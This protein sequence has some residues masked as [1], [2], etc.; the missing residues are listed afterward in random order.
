MVRN[1]PPPSSPTPTAENPQCNLLDVLLKRSSDQFPLTSPLRGFQLQAEEKPT[2]S[3][4]APGLPGCPAAAASRLQPAQRSWWR[5]PRGA[6]P[7]ACPDDLRFSAGAA[8]RSSPDLLLPELL[9]MNS[10]L[11]HLKGHSFQNVLKDGFLASSPGMISQQPLC[12]LHKVW[13]S[14]IPLGVNF[15]FGKAQDDLCW[16]SLQ[17]SEL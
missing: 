10:C 5:R 3:S 1:L 16:S 13:L 12:H 6:D 15:Y 7:A 9:S 4:R 17:A 8:S 14:D 11:W 2:A